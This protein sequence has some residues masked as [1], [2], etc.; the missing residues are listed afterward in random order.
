[1]GKVDFTSGWNTL[2]SAV[3]GGDNRFTVAMA[4]IGVGIIVFFVAK[5][6]WD[7]KRGG[8]AGGMGTLLVPLIIGAALA[9]PAVVIP[10][11]LKI[12]EI[13]VNTLVSFFNWIT[14]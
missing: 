10:A 6:L 4:A 13:V 14:K 2:W 12:A 8:G 5:F 11:I 9:G 3:T 7:R 1:V